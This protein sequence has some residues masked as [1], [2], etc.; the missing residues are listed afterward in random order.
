M[1]MKNKTLNLMHMCEIKHVEKSD[2]Q[3]SQKCDKCDN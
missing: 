1:V 3:K 2:V